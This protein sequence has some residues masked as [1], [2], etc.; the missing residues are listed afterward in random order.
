MVDTIRI[1]STIS[2]EHLREEK[3]NMKVNQ[4]TG[5]IYYYAFINRIY[6][7]YYP[8]T[9]TL[10]IT[11]HFIRFQE[12]SKVKNYDD[13]YTD[14]H[15]LMTLFSHVELGI[16]TF[17]K[18]PVV[19]LLSQKITRIDF[20]FNIE[21]EYV[22]EYIKFFNLYYEKNRNSKFRN[23]T[24]HTVE[25]N[26]LPNSSFYLKTK[27]QYEK[28]LN[29][30]FTINF[31]NKC[32]QLSN[33]CKNEIEQNF[34]SCVS[35]NDIREAVNI[36]RLEVQAHY[37]KIKSICKKFE[38]DWNKRCLKTL[39]D[40]NISREVI[41]D[42]IKRFFTECDFYSFKAAK[43]RVITEHKGDKKLLD[44][45]VAVARNNTTST[46]PRYENTLK[47][48]GIFPYMF[49]PPDWNIPKLENPIKL[50]DKKIKK[51]RLENLTLRKERAI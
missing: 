35:P 2:Y 13:T 50:I 17:F 4:E 30:N 26:L 44:Y 22:N 38:I 41:C 34:R 1:I 18:Y 42:E 45:I 24:N 8:D 21:T 48:M 15:D 23:Y 27:G 14:R 3:W 6:L 19:G 51:N 40:I 12:S 46:Y 31:Y 7:G 36:L 43:E 25:H 9:S 28:N 47:E 33:K 16:S 32:N 5:E 49:I 29:Q 37:V 10:I 11:G 20:C 39:L